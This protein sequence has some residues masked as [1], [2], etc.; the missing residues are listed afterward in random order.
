MSRDFLEIIRGHHDS[1]YIGNDHIK[2]DGKM[3]KLPKLGW[4]KMR[5]VLRFSGK[6]ISATTNYTF[7]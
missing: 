4:V 5:E 7:D 1:F 3:I 2:L 6:V